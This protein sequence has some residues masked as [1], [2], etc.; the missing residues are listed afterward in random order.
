MVALLVRLKLTLLRNSL[1]RSVWRTVGLVI[2]L[3]YG[4]GVVVA[5]LIGMV[6]LRFTSPALTGDVTVLVFGAMTLGWL[7]FSLLVFGVDET[8]DPGK[9]ALFPVSARHL[10]P[11]LFVAGLLGT[12]GVAT[13]LVSTGLVITWSRG[14]LLTIAA[15]V[16][17]PLGIALC[18]LLSRAATAAFASALSA[19][20]FRDF[21]TVALVIF[22][23]G[24]GLL[25]NLVGNF[26]DSN[27][28]QMRGLLANAARAMSWT[29]FGWPWAIPADVAARSWLR[30]AVHLLLTV[31]L[32]SLL[33]WVWGHYLDRNLVSPLETGGGATKV[34]S[35]RNSVGHL[36]P[37]TPAGAVAI[38][39][40]HY[41]RRDPRYLGAIAGMLV[42]PII[43]IVS[44]LITPHGVV[45]LAVFAPAFLGLLLGTSLAQDL[46]YDGNAVWQHV[47]TGIAG[48]DDR[49][50]RSWAILSIALPI[51]IV[52]QLGAVAFA[53]HWELLVSAIAVD[54]VTIMSS[55]GVGAW[56]GAIWQWPAPPPGA[57]PFQKSGSGGG[58]Q[59]ALGFG[60]T[61]GLAL[62]G[63]LPT[64]AMVVAGIWIPWLG[65][66]ALPLGVGT[67][68]LIMKLGLVKGGALL[69]RRWPEVLA[70][71]SARG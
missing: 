28:A 3:I 47:S 29:P 49:R 2:G 43:I 64:I 11:G 54:A 50:G 24:L 39:C 33:W 4:L 68:L 6:A 30:A 58:F 38:R 8:V 53:G 56:A 10:M 59:S 16:A 19:R 48:V 67:G 70:A 62:A 18:F 13:V 21:A 1:R 46:S 55:L 51:M 36:F 5:V 41:W 66:L 65:W 27:P 45:Q 35:R 14:V 9:F 15:V 34:K 61:T 20:K 32:L 17:S 22:G 26:S 69:D 40:L 42:A 31:G 25:G 23:V 71:V 57:N 7:V 63:S 12:P 52:V 44:Q 37:P 60:L